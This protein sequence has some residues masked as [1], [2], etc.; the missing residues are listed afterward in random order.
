MSNGKNG[1]GESGD[2]R[3]PKLNADVRRADERHGGGLVVPRL[4][5]V[6]PTP[7]PDMRPPPESRP[8]PVPYPPGERP[9]AQ[10]E[11]RP[12]V[13][14]PGYP[15][16]QALGADPATT[17][18]PAAPEGVTVG[19]VIFWSLVAF[20]GGWLV[21]RASAADPLG[22]PS[23]ETDPLNEN[24]DED[25]DGNG[26]NGVSGVPKRR[27]RAK[28]KPRKSATRTAK[29]SVQAAPAAV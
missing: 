24:A 1:V 10:M 5:I 13:A 19:K 18:A 4:R 12:T 2:D 21:A 8:S 23:W 27:R 16:Q 25:E 6:D 3:V 17:P 26:S 22:N 29:R 7:P 20:A 14:I 15:P 9:P 28:R 11:R